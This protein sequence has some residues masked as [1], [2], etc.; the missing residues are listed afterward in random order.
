MYIPF[1]IFQYLFHQFKTVWMGNAESQQQAGQDHRGPGTSNEMRAC[2]YEVLE[3]E[4]SD[5]TT[6]EDIKKVPL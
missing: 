5:E 2:Y 6:T 1:L 4:R 3:V